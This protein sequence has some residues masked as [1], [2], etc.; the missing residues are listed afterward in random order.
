MAANIIMML[1]GGVIGLG[2]VLLTSFGQLAKL[3]AA[4]SVGNPA[5]TT[6]TDPGPTAT[7][8]APYDQKDPLLS[9]CITAQTI[10]LASR[11]A[12][13]PLDLL[14]VLNLTPEQLGR[15]EDSAYPGRPRYREVRHIITDAWESVVDGARQSGS[16]QFGGE[17]WVDAATL[18]ADAL[19]DDRSR[20][21]YLTEIVPSLEQEHKKTHGKR[22]E[23]WDNAGNPSNDEVRARVFTKYCREI[24]ASL[25][26]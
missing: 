21:A 14:A 23:Y 13:M 10:R 12:T 11:T 8:H 17:V 18:A 22:S 3:D 20:Q 2:G 5:A 4:P 25:G 7:Y 26:A 6:M 19:L 9:V 15:P 24:W 16:D 1:A